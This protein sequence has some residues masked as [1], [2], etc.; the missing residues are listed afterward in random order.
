MNI[1][2]CL[3]RYFRLL[4]SFEAFKLLH[5]G[6]IIEIKRKSLPAI[7]RICGTRQPSKLTSLS[8]ARHLG[9]SNSCVKNALV[10]ILKVLH[11]RTMILLIDETGDCK[12]G[13][14]TST[15]QTTI[16]W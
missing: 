16:H 14:S 1:V 9:Q 6:M 15:C 13:K 10:L 2:N 7:A 11:G 3:G 8:H 5:L 4:R 12:K